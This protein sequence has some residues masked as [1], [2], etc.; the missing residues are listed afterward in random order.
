MA[1]IARI[2]SSAPISRASIA[3]ARANRRATWGGTGGVATEAETPPSVSP[4]KTEC[5]Q[6]FPAW[7]GMPDTCVLRAGCTKGPLALQ[8]YVSAAHTTIDASTPC[9]DWSVAKCGL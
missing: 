5:E 8:L 2:A 6:K 7:L 1:A 3:W 4:E 9:H